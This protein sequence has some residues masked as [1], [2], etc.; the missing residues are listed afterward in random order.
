LKLCL[1]YRLFFSAE[2]ERVEVF[3]RVELQL[4]RVYTLFFC[5]SAQTRSVEHATWDFT[6]FLTG[7]IFFTR[8]YRKGRIRRRS[9]VLFERCLGWNGTRSRSVATQTDRWHRRKYE[10]DWGVTTA[11]L[12]PPQ[13]RRGG[14]IMTSPAV[15]GA[16]LMTKHKLA[17]APRRVALF[18]LN[19]LYIVKLLVK[20]SLIKRR[21]ERFAAALV[22]GAR[23]LCM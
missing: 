21:A 23:E 5:T 14:S 19:A 18:D 2:K 15:S 10:F 1:A 17:V 11:T 13:S 22:R 20:E 6:I 12:T 9:P 16:Q 4:R 7:A 3:W 8:A